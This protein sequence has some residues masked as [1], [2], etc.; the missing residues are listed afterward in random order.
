MPRGLTPVESENLPP[1]SLARQAQVGGQQ[2]Q[3]AG[4]V[5]GADGK[6]VLVRGTDELKALLRRRVEDRAWKADEK[7]AGRGFGGAS[8][9]KR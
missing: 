2:E 5:M 9:R 6:E 4:V 7:G 3:T 8:N 1:L